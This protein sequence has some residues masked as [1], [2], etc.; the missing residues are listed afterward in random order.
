MQQNFRDITDAYEF[1]TGSA[2]SLEIYEDLANLF[3]KQENISDD[4]LDRLGLV[5]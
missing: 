2:P 4:M 3:D 5:L 1:D